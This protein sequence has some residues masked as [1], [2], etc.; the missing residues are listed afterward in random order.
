MIIAKRLK[1]TPVIL[2]RANSG[3]TA[4]ERGRVVG[5]AAMAFYERGQKE[6]EVKKMAEL[7]QTQGRALLLLARRTILARLKGDL[8]GNQAAELEKALTDP[9]FK[10][11]RGVFV[12]LNRRGRLRGCIGSLAAVETIREGVRRNALNAAFS[13]PRFPPLSEEELD[14]LEIEVSLLTEAT[15]L[16][17]SDSHDLLAKLRPGIDGVIIRDGIH[18][19]TFLPQVWSNY[20]TLPIF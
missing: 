14:D 1:L 7:D 9:A 10:E 6:S 2:A 18:T 15:P 20:P 17:F 3:D 11:K 13:D 19:A 4:G 8:P 5:Y 16:E 12:T